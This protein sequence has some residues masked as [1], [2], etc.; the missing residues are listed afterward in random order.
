MYS[1]ISE[2]TV[3]V[4]TGLNS[5]YSPFQPLFLPRLARLLYERQE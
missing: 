4:G 2:N 1:D 5:S 3:S